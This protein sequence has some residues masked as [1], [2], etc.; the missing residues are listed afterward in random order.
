M[1][2]PRMRTI[3]D[4]FR[5]D[6]PV[7]SRVFR[8]QPRTQVEFASGAGI[9]AVTAGPGAK[10][11]VVTLDGSQATVLT[12]AITNESLVFMTYQD[13]EGSPGPI[14]VASRTPGVSFLIDGDG[15]A[16]ISRVA[17]MIVE[18]A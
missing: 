7:G 14:R 8:T 12:T 17:W 11:G 13:D 10:F 16:N 6:I 1:A 4:L 18:P 2:G 3:R 5:L 15:S 9:C